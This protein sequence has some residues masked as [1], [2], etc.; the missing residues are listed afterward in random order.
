M[1]RNSVV[2]TP[3][4]HALVSVDVE[5]VNSLEGPWR[6]FNLESSPSQMVQDMGCGNLVTFITRKSLEFLEQPPHLFDFIFLDGSHAASIVYQEIPLALRA[7]AKNG[8]ILL[9]DFFPNN[10]PL[11]SSNRRIIPGPWIAVERL[12]V[13]GAALAVQPLGALPWATKLGSNVTSLALLTVPPS[14]MSLQYLLK[15]GLAQ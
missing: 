13:E 1:K 15:R 10:K 14:R 5:D 7:L 11:W 9:H 8:V 4:V 12:R 2:G 6:R 3:A